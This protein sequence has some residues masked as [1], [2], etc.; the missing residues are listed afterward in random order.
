MLYLGAHRDSKRARKYH[1]IIHPY[2]DI[3]GCKISEVI[4]L[5]A[6]S[7]ICRKTSLI[8]KVT[9]LFLFVFETSDQKNFRLKFMIK[10]Q[11]FSMMLQPQRGTYFPCKALCLGKFLYKERHLT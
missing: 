10:C 2:I 4:Q 7:K 6:G 1:D 11:Y 3:G 5:S 8:A 9:V